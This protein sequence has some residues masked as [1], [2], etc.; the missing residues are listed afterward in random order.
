M[1]FREA[2]AALI[3]ALR[4]GDFQHEVRDSIEV[5]NL[6]A[7]GQISAEDVIDI[8]ARCKGTDYSCSKHHMLKSIDVHVIVKNG[9]YIKY[10]IIHPDVWFISV[11][12]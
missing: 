4:S 3:N 5:K 10:Y 2:K 12:R 6:L 7:V 1:G 8:V 9:W 11:H